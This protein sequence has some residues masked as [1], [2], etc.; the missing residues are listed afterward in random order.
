VF[1]HSITHPP[2]SGLYRLVICAALLIFAVSGNAFAHGVTFKLQ[3]AQP[4]DSAFSK[5]FLDL[6]ANKIHDESR[7]RVNL[8]ITPQNQGGAGTDLFQVVLDRTAD[9]VWLDL[10]KPAASFPIFSVF[11]MPL[12]GT[13]S[14][15]SSRA[16]WSWIDI[17]NLGFREFGELR[18][19]AASRHDTPAFH[20]REKQ[21]SSLSDLKGAKIAIPTSDAETF[22][23]GLGAS[24]VV[25]SGP[26]MRDALAQSSVDGVLLSWSALASTKLD[27]LVKMHA[28]A[29]VGAPWAYAE[30]SVLLMNPDAYRSLA[31]DL[32]Q[33][34]RNNSGID[35]SA[36]IGKSFDEIALRA[37]KR[38]A[39]RG[40]ALVN[41]PESD[42]DKWREAC[43][44]PIDERVK[45]LDARGLKGEELITRARAL[46]DEYDSAD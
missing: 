38:A 32:K 20:M 45:D 31:D 37:R 41:L 5:S 40:D 6:W 19:L 34:I 23:T 25:I 3:T 13:T 16:L 18:I 35:A 21:V 2:L 30:L 24:P 15:G 1:A 43:N 17:N 39:D 46:I 14:E 9:I 44:A 22:L 29:P 10:Q 26:A 7:G 12:E 28:T 8:L 42:L 36:Q 11:G 27:E 33:V 4:I